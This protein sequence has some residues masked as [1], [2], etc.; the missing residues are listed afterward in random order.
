MKYQSSPVVVG[1]L[2]YAGAGKDSV[3]AVFEECGY[4]RL[5]FADPLKKVAFDL[6][7]EVREAVSEHGV[8]AAKRKHESVRQ[9]YQNL[10]KSLR[11]ALYEDIWLEALFRK[12]E[13]L[14]SEQGVERFVISDVRYDN[15][16]QAILR[17]GKGFI[18][19]VDR[20]GFGPVNNHDSERLPRIFIP[21]FRIVNDG[22]LEQLKNKTFEAMQALGLPIYE[23]CETK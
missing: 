8:D 15:E 11:D 6:F 16:A 10:G 19:G 18:V 14:S 7:P 12:M 2:G 9:I 21:D 3:A 4:K 1:L 17:F 20:P 22:S 5:A 13:K 23:K